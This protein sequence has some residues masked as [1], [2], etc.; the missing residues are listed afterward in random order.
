MAVTSAGS[1]IAIPHGKSE[2]VLRPGIAVGKLR[3]KILWTEDYTLE[4]DERYVQVVILFAVHPEDEERDDSVYIR[5]LKHVFGRLGEKET[6]RRLILA[7][8]S[9]TI[10]Q[11]LR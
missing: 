7:K 2:S 6:A 3:E 9:E 10:R 8:D 1:Y 11:L 4:E 5:M